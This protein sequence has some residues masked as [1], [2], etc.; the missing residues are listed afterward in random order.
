MNTKL[1]RPTTYKPE[2]CQMLIDHMASGLSFESFAGVCRVSKQT[3]YDW[4]N[5]N[6]D[7]LDAKSK[8]LELN[9]L[10]WEQKGRDYLIEDSGKDVITQKLN[11]TVYV[12]NMKNRFPKEW[13]DKQEIEHSGTT[14]ITHKLPSLTFEQAYEIVH[15]KKPE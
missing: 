7:F 8:G 12:F 5:A 1:G 3:I 10:W 14:E 15:G 2:Y 11:S 4:L 13:R 9:R 6:P